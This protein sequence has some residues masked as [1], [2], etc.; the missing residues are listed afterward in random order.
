MPFR[1]MW[2]FRF[3][4]S[5]RSSYLEQNKAHQLQ[6]HGELNQKIVGFL[7]F[8]YLLQVLIEVFS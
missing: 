8:Q 1:F 7:A 4:P 6:G 3:V 5:A 2:V